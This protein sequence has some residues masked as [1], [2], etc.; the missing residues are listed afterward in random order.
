MFPYITSTYIQ[1]T[2]EY[3]VVLGFT[4]DEGQAAHKDGQHRLAAS[5]PFLNAWQG[6]RFQ[7]VQGKGYSAWLTCGKPWGQ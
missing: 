7:G 5:H 6:V 1:E 3:R 2:C 4:Q